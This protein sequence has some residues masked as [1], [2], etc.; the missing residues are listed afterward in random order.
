M[1]FAGLRRFGY[2]ADDTLDQRSRGA[3]VAI[4]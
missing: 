1:Q 2:L 4:G 3:N